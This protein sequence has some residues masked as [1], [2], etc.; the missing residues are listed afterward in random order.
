MGSV[1]I[2][3]KYAAQTHA[4]TIFFLW[5]FRLCESVKTNSVDLHELKNVGVLLEK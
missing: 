4:V 1:T 3:K 5:C 2:L